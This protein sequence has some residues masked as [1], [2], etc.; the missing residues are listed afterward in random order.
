MADMNLGMTERLKPIHQRVA[1]M[2]RDEIAPLG[3]E[4]LAEVGRNGDRWAYTARQTEILEGLKKT[5]RERGLWNFWL[6]D[7][8]RGYG[9]STVEYAYLAEEMGKA[10]LGAE[11]F[12][13]SAPDT[14]NM[15]V[16]E[17]HGS[18]EH[19]REWLEPLLEGKIR[20]AYLMTEPDVA[21]SDATNISMRCERRGDDYVLN[22][23]KWWASGAGDPRCAIYIVMVRTGSEEEPQHRRHSMILVPSDSKGITKLRPMQV[24]GDDDAPHG[25]M[26]L[27]FEDV[28]V[29]AA[30][31][32]LG[33]GRGFEISQGRLG[34]GRI[35]H[36]MRAIGQAEMALEMLCQRSVR[37]E[38]FG[39]PLARLGA[40]FDII[41]ECR[42]EIEMARLLCLKAAWMID[43]GDA[44][45]A[46]PW[47]SQIKVVAP[48]VALK[49]TDEAV[50]MF[51]AQ[52]I[53]QDTPLARS[54][55]HLRTLRLADGPDAVHR[56][57]VARAE[58]RKY[59]QEKV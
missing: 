47:I 13:C 54:W 40:N 36:C 1:A 14:G 37:R 22:G 16:L 7:S 31:L 39:Q 20:S 21:S 58:L 29:P 59:T 52:G 27:R 26:H 33:E 2:V 25:H 50:Q 53:S 46:A 17:R 15:E 5:A 51:G 19:K 56:R 42:M 45:A 32:I 49:V 18:E 34:P 9:L 43:Q 55:T 11:T 3:E 38:A 23:E 24:Y 4:F 41:A 48:R 30:N 6:T 10:H 44:R 28:R 57:Q 12:N 8:K 35:H